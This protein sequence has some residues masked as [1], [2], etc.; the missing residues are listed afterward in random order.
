MALGNLADLE[1]LEPTPGRPD[2]L[3]LY[4]KVGTSQEGTEG[5]PSCGWGP[6]LPGN[7]EGQVR[8]EELYV[9]WGLSPIRFPFC[10]YHVRIRCRQGCLRGVLCSRPGG[11]RA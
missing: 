11:D 6:L 10:V 3:T 8:R 5:K 7:W 4:H 1:E 9:F 2:P